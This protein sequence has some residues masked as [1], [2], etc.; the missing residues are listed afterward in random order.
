M[1][2]LP[3]LEKLEVGGLT[4]Q[5]FSDLWIKDWD[6]GSQS[7]D[8]SDLDNPVYDDTYFGI[9]Y[10]RAPTWTFEFIIEGRTEI[11]V[12]DSLDA[13]KAA[14]RNPKFTKE[15]GET[16][17]L[18]FTVAGRR[19]V[20]YG[21][22]RRFAP[23]R[24]ETAQQGFI[25]VLADFQLSDPLQYDGGS[26][27]GWVT[28]RLE[29]VPPDTRGLEEYLTEDTLTTEVGGVRQGQLPVV[30]GHAPTP[31]KCTL[32]GPNLNPGFTID[33]R[34]YQF[35]T[36]L[37]ANQRLVVDSRTGTVLR[38]GY[39]NMAHTMDR[40]VP[41]KGVRLEPGRA[42][43]VSFFGEDPTLTSYAYFAFR[44]AHY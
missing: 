7:I 13:V 31:F 8:T 42:V 36:S 17:E 15:A 4:F 21:R 34:E 37:S 10:H 14:W 1:E 44:P 3:S 30:T 43:E 9:D 5:D 12:L 26:N 18:A 16:T 38:N 27:D 11:D 35:N 2:N 19:R 22:P 6:L 20:V 28:T 25:S 32:Y 33:G 39:T 40:P 29:S 23:A 24:I 41:L